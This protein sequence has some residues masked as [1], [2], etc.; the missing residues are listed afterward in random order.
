MAKDETKTSGATPLPENKNEVTAKQIDAWKK[1]FED[2][3]EI[4]CNGKLGIKRGYYKKPNRK[5]LGAAMKFGQ[6]DPMKFNETLATNCWL[7]GDTEMQTNDAY[8]MAAASKFS[9]LVDLGEA[10]I[11]KL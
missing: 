9:D 11:K 10:S 4:E 8:F 1:E 3:W 2:I 5:I 6:G 7:G